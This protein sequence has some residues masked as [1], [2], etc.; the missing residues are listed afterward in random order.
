MRRQRATRRRPDLEL[1]GREIARLRAQMRRG[2]PFAV[3]ILAMALRTIVQI[4]LLAG[5]PLCVGPEVGRCRAY[6]SGQRGTQCG[7]ENSETAAGYRAPR[8]PIGGHFV[9]LSPPAR[10]LRPVKS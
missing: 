5:L 6:P 2:I 1:A 4:E 9:P 8:A 3:P 7:H 10:G